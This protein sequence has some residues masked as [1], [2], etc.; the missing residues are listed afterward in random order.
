MSDWKYCLFSVSGLKT[1]INV[2]KHKA[3]KTNLEFQFTPLKVGRRKL[4]H[5]RTPVRTG[6][7][8]VQ[9]CEIL[10]VQ[11]KWQHLTSDGYRQW[12]MYSCGNSHEVFIQPR[13]FTPEENGGA[14]G[15]RM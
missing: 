14:N 6:D 12:L 11:S 10:N 15:S 13:T 1:L 9:L 8:T 4:I 2:K 5:Y 7:R 3:L